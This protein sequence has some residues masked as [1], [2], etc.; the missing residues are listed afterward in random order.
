ME[1][2]VQSKVVFF[3]EEFWTF[4]A[5][6]L[7]VALA[8]MAVKQIVGV[9]VP[10]ER[11]A[12]DA[13]KTGTQRANVADIAVDPSLPLWYR[14]WRATISMHPVIVGGLMGLAPIPVARWVPNSN[15]AHMLWFALAGA[16]SGQLFEIIKRLTE[17]IPA[18]IRQRLG[19][20]SERPPPPP[21]EEKVAELA[22][23]LEP[24]PEE[25]PK[26]E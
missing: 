7:G 17:I 16:L 24:E 2:V 15:A 9:I 26:E 12:A 3:F 25:K 8:G 5:V 23:E 4:V 14:L 21:P 13:S 18:V 11:L 10:A 20:K 19:M 6:S 22:D 1:D